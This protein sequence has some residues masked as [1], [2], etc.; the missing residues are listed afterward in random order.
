MRKRIVKLLNPTGEKLDLFTMFL[1]TVAII[2]LLI[3][4]H[5]IDKLFQLD[6]FFEK[7]HILLDR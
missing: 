3:F 7:V 5:L 2:L 6:R 1:Y 4:F